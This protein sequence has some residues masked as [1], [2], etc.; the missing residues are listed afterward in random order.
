MEPSDNNNNNNNNNTTRSGVEM[1]EKEGKKK[2][3]AVFLKIFSRAGRGQTPH[4]HTLI[5][6]RVSYPPLKY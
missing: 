2:K 6:Y 4:D 5:Q 3:C 1:N